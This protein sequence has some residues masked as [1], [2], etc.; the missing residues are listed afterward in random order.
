MSQEMSHPA[1]VKKA[2]LSALIGSVAISALLGIAA[3]LSGRFGWFEVRILLTT[4]TIAAASVCGLACGAHLATRQGRALPLTGIGLTGVA[5]AMVIAGIWTEVRSE[6]FW[7]TAACTSVFAVAC[8]HLSLLSMARLADWFRWSLAAA[9]ITIFGVA[10]LVAA[11][12]LGEADSPGMFQL[13]GVAAIL[14]ASITILIPIFHRM[15]RGDLA[16]EGAEAAAVSIEA[17]DAELA[18]L[19]ARIAEL[20]GLRGSV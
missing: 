11:M 19:R 7:K 18:Q 9:Y 6:E 2:F 20:E 13:M 14:D 17:I 5:A 16:R 10:F 15:S 1:S 12:I 8:A 3:I 4:V